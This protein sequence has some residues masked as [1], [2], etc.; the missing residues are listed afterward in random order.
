[1]VGAP[2]P[3]RSS[4][5]YAVGVVNRRRHAPLFR[6]VAA[7]NG[8]VLVVACLL[9]AVVLAPGDLGSV[10]P[11]EAAILVGAL[12]AIAVLNL[13]VLR[14]AF[15]PLERLAALSRRVDPT[16]PGQRVPTTGPA[17]EATELAHAFNEMLERLEDERRESSRRVLEGQEAERLRV[18]QELHDEVGQTLTAVLLQLGRIEKAVPD[19]LRDSVDEAQETARASLEDV[20]RIALELRPEALDDLGLACALQALTARMSDGTGVRVTCNGVRDLPPLAPDAELVLYRVA[21]EA[22]TNVVRHSG[23]ATAELRLQR[24]S[25]QLT[26]AVRDDGCGLEPDTPDGTGMRGMR[27]RANLVGARLE[28]GALPSGGTEV[29]LELPVSEDGRWGR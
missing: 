17:S 28:V 13:L 20:R 19:G 22:L 12:G 15:A 4:G 21:Q 16:R 5:F 10:A 18:A 29:R 11:E 8:I 26:L 14:R 7:I 1:M 3:R 9:T 24:A 25:G 2:H 23:S 27:E 6:Q